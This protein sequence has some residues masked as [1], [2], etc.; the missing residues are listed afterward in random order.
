MVLKVKTD[1]TCPGV[2]KAPDDASLTNWDLNH[3]ATTNNPRLRFSMASIRKER[4]EEIFGRKP[5][6]ARSR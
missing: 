4:W 1:P 3:N 2:G 5:R 6:N